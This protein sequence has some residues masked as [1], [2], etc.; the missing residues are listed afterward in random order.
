[1]PA[2]PRSNALGRE[3]WRDLGPFLLRGEF[4]RAK[5]RDLV[6][7]ARVE[8][9]LA[10][11]TVLEVVVLDPTRAFLTSS[12]AN[13][14]SRVVVGGL[15]FRLVAVGKDGPRVR[16]TFEDAVVDRLKHVT[17]VEKSV[18]GRLNRVRAVRSL[19]AEV[20]GLRVV[21]PDRP[22]AELP[23]KPEEPEAPDPTLASTSQ[24]TADPAGREPGFPPGGPGGGLDAEQTAVAETMLT[25]VY[26]ATTSASNEVRTRVMVATIMAGLQESGLRNLTHGHSSSVGVLQLLDIHLG[27]STSTNG[28]RRDVALVTRLFVEQGFT[29]AGGAL[30]IVR[31]NPSMA[32][33]EVVARVQGNANGARDYTKHQTLAEHVVSEF[34]PSG[35]ESGE[36]GGGSGETVGR[37]TAENPTETSWEALQRLAE[38]IAWRAF[39]VDDTLYYLDDLTLMQSAARMVLSPSADGFLDL[40]GDADEGLVAQEATA[41]V[42]AEEWRGEPGTTVDVREHGPFDGRWLVDGFRRDLFSPVAEVTLT[43]PRRALPEPSEDSDTGGSALN[44]VGGTRGPLGAQ[45]AALAARFL[46]VL[47]YAQTRPMPASLEPGATTDCSGFVTTLY[48]MAGAPDPNGQGYSGQGSTGT[49]WARGRSVEVADLVAG[50]LVFYGTPAAAG[51]AAHVAVCIGN[52]EAIGHGS[53]GGARRHAVDYRAD[54]AGARRYL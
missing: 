3:P 44:D 12:L 52:G 2:R 47:H 18:R 25:A 53:E 43:R 28:G 46:G 9:T 26:R 22:W 10:G 1:M 50:D 41:Y 5:L 19:A 15:A 30:A 16:L 17:G 49:L 23:D 37:G 27:G 24:T 38:E 36:A 45:I 34:L 7:S 14:R 32:L 29:G 6:V 40:D 48:R 31:A 54:Y 4:E 13:E 11:P 33:D 21:T 35:A 20:P 51:G 39:V 42:T 8:R